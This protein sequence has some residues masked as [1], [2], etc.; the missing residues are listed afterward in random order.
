[1][2][3]GWIGSKKWRGR[4][5][6]VEVGRKSQSDEERMLRAEGQGK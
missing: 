5:D 3:D 4:E 6:E 1:M 2:M